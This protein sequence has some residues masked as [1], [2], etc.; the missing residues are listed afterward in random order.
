MPDE[1]CALGRR[2]RRCARPPADTCQ[3]CARPFCREHAYFL[4]GYDAVCARPACA[5][6]HDDLPGHHDYVRGVRRR[7]HGGLCGFEACAHPHAFDCGK[8]G[9]RFCLA[10]LSDERYPSPGALEP[11][12]MVIVCAHCWQRRVIWGKA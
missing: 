10:H 7:N 6:K 5:A 12:E 9:G 1:R 3:Y 8:C 4:E 2:W 11:A